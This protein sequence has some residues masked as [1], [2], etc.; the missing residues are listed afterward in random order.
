[1]GYVVERVRAEDN[2]QDELSYGLEASGLNGQPAPQTPL[3]FAIDN[4]TGIISLN[5]TLKGRVRVFPPMRHVVCMCYSRRGFLRVQSAE[6]VWIY[7]VSAW[8]C[9]K[10]EIAA[11]DSEEKL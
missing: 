4:T 2:E 11:A 3:P 7:R 9:H 10:V 1:M 8:C 6:R 5:E